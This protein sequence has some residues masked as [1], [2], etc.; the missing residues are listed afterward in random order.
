MESILQQLFNGTYDITPKPDQ[1]QQELLA[2]IFAETDRI[3][4]ALGADFLDRLLSLDGERAERQNFHYF[5]S[6]FLAGA[7]LMLEILH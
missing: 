1:K 6:G 7:R 2:Q 5:R 4:A 3:Q